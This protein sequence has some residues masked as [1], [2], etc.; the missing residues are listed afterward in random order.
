MVCL[1][2]YGANNILS[3]SPSRIVADEMLRSQIAEIIAAMDAPDQAADAPVQMIRLLIASTALTIAVISS[4]PLLID[5]LKAFIVLAA[6]IARVIEFE[7]V[8][9]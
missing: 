8:F 9:S 2:I 4:E 3:C 7:Q 5:E 1:C 6:P